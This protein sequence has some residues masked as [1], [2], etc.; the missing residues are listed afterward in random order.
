MSIHRRLLS[1]ARDVRLV[2][3]ATLVLICLAWVGFFNLHTPSLGA[4]VPVSSRFM[5]PASF[6][7][8]VATESGLSLGELG[9]LTQVTTAPTYTVSFPL[10]FTRFWREPDS[11]LGVQLYRD[12]PEQEAVLK[13]SQAGAQWARLAFLWSEVEPANTTPENFQWPASFDDWLARLS[14]ENVNVILMFTGNPSWAAEYPGG[15]LRDGVP[16]AELVEFMEAA[17]AH[18]SAS[19]YNVK[20]WEFYNE[21]D[22]GDEQFAEDGWGYFGDTPEEYASLL[23]AVYAPMKAVDPETQI[24]FGGLSYDWFTS[25]DGPFVREF[26]DGV[27]ENGGGSYFDLMN[28][29]YYR[30]FRGRWEP[31]GVDII[32]KTN[33]LRDK[34]ASYDLD[35]P[36]ICTE[37]GFWSENIGGGSPEEQS[38]YVPQVFARSMAAGLQITIWFRLIDEEGLGAR[39]WGLV[40]ADLTPKPSYYA[41]QTLA[42]QLG[43]TDYVRTLT[44]A[45]TGTGAIEAYEFASHYGSDRII[46]AWTE[47]GLYHQITLIGIQVV[48]V[49]KF[50]GQ[51]P[52]WDGDDGAVDGKVRVNIGPSP[53]YLQVAH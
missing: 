10:V 37:T 6:P 43:P 17:V 22:N 9:A 52:V 34:L 13:A 15:P 18:Y 29:H 5:V 36:I 32:G 42:Q 48:V 21:P 1:R 20:V 30:V 26:L 39:K 16:L 28:F 19:P 27:L 45:D 14:A 40:D 51:T 24:V 49:D 23:Q 35:K 47:D 25:E 8:A 44:P 38:R 31:Y 11:I 12:H 53:V 7:S 50:G 2:S 46:V 3:A 4:S 41:F 33:Y